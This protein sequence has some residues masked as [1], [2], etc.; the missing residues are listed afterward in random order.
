LPIKAESFSGLK[1]QDDELVQALQFVLWKLEA[2]RHWERDAIF[3]D[4]KGLADTLGVKVKDFFAPLFIA[5]SGSTASISVIDSMDILGPDMS[6]ARVR[7]AIEVLGGVGKK[8]LKKME[9]AYAQLDKK[10]G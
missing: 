4:M 9:K 10:S 3:T 2:L 7:H 6:R 5:I 8:K 1:L